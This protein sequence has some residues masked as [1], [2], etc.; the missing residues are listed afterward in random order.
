VAASLL[1]W[2]LDGGTLSLHH[3]FHPPTFA[4]QCKDHVGGMIVLPG[5]ALMPCAA[6]DYFNGAA[7]TLIALWR[8]PEQL[9][10][11]AG[12][13][14][15]CA[16]VDLSSFGE[17][18][19]IAAH[20]AADRLPV[21]IPLGT[22]G[23]Q[24]SAGSI[25]ETQRSKNG[26]LAVRGAM[27][28]VYAFPPGTEVGRNARLP[29]DGDGFV[30][31]GFTCRVDGAASVLTITGPPGGIATIGGYRFRPADVENQVA[32]ADP[33]ATVVALPGGPIAQRLAGSA[34]DPTAVRAALFKNGANPLLVGA[35]QPRARAN[36]A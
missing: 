6:E 4:A 11:A 29:V 5:P 12:W 25:T 32:V 28:P 10:S 16:V 19:L 30:D 33:G 15:E 14:G 20:R 34:L 3:G 17:A 31:T 35:F 9:A 36:A 7:T 18:G 13:R 23:A 24:H 26:T 2:L 27:V 1:P 8:S 22:I 21:D